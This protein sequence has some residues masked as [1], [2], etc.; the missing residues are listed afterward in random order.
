VPDKPLLIEQILDL[1]T[2][3]PSRIAVHSEGLTPEQL[4]ARP[5]PD[6]WSANEV[7]AHLRSCAD[8]WGDCIRLIVTED[9]PTF[10]AVNPRTWIKNTDYPEQEF[11]PSFQAFAAQR[12]DLLAYLASLEPD[13]WQCSATVNVA[14]RPL[15]RTVHFYAQWLATHER[16]HVKQIGR[17][18]EVVRHLEFG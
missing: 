14:G 13:D 9:R 10:R 5:A 3:G 12:A 2:E 6:E 16:P 11:R 4:R 7:L 8:V 1:L 17:I 18:T 15:E